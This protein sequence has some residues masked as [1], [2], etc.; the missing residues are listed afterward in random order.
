[1][2]QVCGWIRA[3]CDNS[4]FSLLPGEDQAWKTFVEEVHSNGATEWTKWL[5]GKTAEAAFDLLVSAFSHLEYNGATPSRLDQLFRD[6]FQESQSY[7]LFHIYESNRYK[8]WIKAKS[9][10]LHAETPKVQ[11]HKTA[12]GNTELPVEE[13][14]FLNLKQDQED[15]IQPLFKD[16]L[17]PFFIG[18]NRQRDEATMLD[19]YDSQSK[20]AGFTGLALPIYDRW[21]ADGPLGA[22]VGWL[23]LA[24]EEHS[25][26]GSFFDKFLGK[27]VEGHLYREILRANLNDYAD[28]LAEHVLDEELAAYSPTTGE[29][30][31]DYFIRRFHH[32]EGWIAKGADCD[33][34]PTNHFFKYEPEQASI[35]IRLDANTCIRLT[36]KF[37]TVRP[38]VPDPDELSE[39]SR[40]YFLRVATWARTLWED[41]HHIHAQYKAGQLEGRMRVSHSIPYTISIHLNKLRSVADAIEHLRQSVESFPIT[42]YGELPPDIRSFRYPVELYSLAV[43]NA[44]LHPP[45]SDSFRRLMP[46]IDWIDKSITSS[47]LTDSSIQQL[48]DSISRPLAKISLQRADIVRNPSAPLRVT[49]A[50]PTIVLGFESL[51]EGRI[52]ISVVIEFL[53]EAFHHCGGLAP[54]VTVELCSQSKPSV[55]V[56]NTCC[57]D[58]DPRRLGGGNQSAILSKLAAHLPGWLILEPE[59]ADGKWHREIRKRV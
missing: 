52:F 8:S 21:E 35:L 23:F 19:Q 41:L 55:F 44:V 45:D 20:S 48:A 30:P 43:E 28:S 27:N 34:L 51:F 32:V 5:S 15:A 25:D 12:E 54:L 53:R 16:F 49:G 6:N 50:L 38:R 7:P 57:E 4:A 13:A 22:F 37:D 11:C 39:T 40:T 18:Q 36:P 42:S 31:L 29:T 2:K 9:V 47:G 24:F 46:V 17:D 56:R 1:M 58:A 26:S 10:D 59:M 33:A 14:G 3:T